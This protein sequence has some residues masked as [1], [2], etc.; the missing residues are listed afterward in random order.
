MI[1]PNGIQVTTSSGSTYGFASLISRDAAYDLLTSVWH[2]TE[3]NSGSESAQLLPPSK[4]EQGD[5][6]S[7]VSYKD[8][9]GRSRKFRIKT[10][11]SS[12]KSSIRS[13]SGSVSHSG[14]PSPVAN[15]VSGLTDS[16][17]IARDTKSEVVEWDGEEYKNEAGEFEL[18]KDPKTSLEI[19]YK[20]LEFLKPFL[21]GTEEV[22]G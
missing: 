12:I 5:D 7:A 10:L 17:K 11:A 1:I 16:Q 21:E 22:K 3:S 20:D 8:D 4:S 2:H 19:M 9:E 15:R 6:S 13:R 18:R 14:T